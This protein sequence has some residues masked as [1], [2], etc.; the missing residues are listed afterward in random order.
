MRN[1]AQTMARTSRKSSF[2]LFLIFCF[3]FAVKCARATSTVE[4]PETK[5]I[6]E[7]IYEENFSDETTKSETKTSD[8]VKPLTGH[9]GNMNLE[10]SRVRVR[11]SH[12]EYMKVSLESRIKHLMSMISNPREQTKSELLKICKDDFNDEE[13]LKKCQEKI[14]EY[15]DEKDELEKKKSALEAEIAKKN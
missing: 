12:F 9:C 5:S 6:S 14:K 8:D 2:G 4:L 10:L 1:K 15:T 7:E 13:M 3:F 11:L